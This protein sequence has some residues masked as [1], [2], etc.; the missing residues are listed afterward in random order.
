M[1][2]GDEHRGFGIGV[3]RGAKEPE[4]HIQM[5]C[6]SHLLPALASPRSPVLLPHPQPA[7]TQGKPPLVVLPPSFLEAL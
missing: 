2:S 5:H 1:V 4:G 7:F 3:P 6:S